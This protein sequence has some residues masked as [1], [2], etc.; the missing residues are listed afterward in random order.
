VSIL[1]VGRGLHLH[2]I[3]VTFLFHLLPTL[4]NEFVTLPELYKMRHNDCHVLF[5]NDG[6]FTQNLCWLS[7]F[8]LQSGVKH[9]VMKVITSIHAYSSKPRALLRMLHFDLFM[10]VFMD[11]DYAKCR[12]SEPQASC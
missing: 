9:E 3:N 5:R 12:K 6:T 1:H 11:Y 4:V 2:L 8:L 7:V 10:G